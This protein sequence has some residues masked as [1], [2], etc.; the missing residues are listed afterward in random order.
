MFHLFF[1]FFGNSTDEEIQLSLYVQA[2]NKKYFKR[3]DLAAKEEEDYWKRHRGV[4][5]DNQKSPEKVGHL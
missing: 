3:G 1:I 4:H 2:P 5:D